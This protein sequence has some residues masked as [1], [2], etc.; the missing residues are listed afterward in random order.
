MVISTT[1]DVDYRHVDGWHIFQAVAMPGFYV[2]HRDPRR[3]YEAVGPAIEKLVKLD[4]D[5][6]CKAVPDVPLKEFISGVRADLT[7]AQSKRFTLLKDA[8]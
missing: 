4:T 3:A 6:D 8:A 2:A 7:V 5:I 1:I